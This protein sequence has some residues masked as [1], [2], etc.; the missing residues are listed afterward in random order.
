MRFGSYE[1]WL[2]F[3]DRPLGEYSTHVVEDALEGPTLAISYV[4]SQVGKVDSAQCLLCIMLKYF[5]RVSASTG[6]TTKGR[7]RFWSR[8]G[9]MAFWSTAK[10]MARG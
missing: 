6:V 9:W 2:A 4:M 5:L 1:C 7:I 8:R 10:S 3:D